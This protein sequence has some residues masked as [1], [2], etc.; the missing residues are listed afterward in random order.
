MIRSLRVRCNGR[1][2]ALTVPDH[3]AQVVICLVLLWEQLGVASL[4]GFSVML[5][6][7]P[8]QAGIARLQVCRIGYPPRCH[9]PTVMMMMM[10]RG[11]GTMRVLV[12]TALPCTAIA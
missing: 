1:L 9:G 2:C 6:V 5:L 3:A 11:S 4:V 10:M 7:L 8:L 12:Q